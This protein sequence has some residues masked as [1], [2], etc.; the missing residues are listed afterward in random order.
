M[1]IVQIEKNLQKLVKSSNEKTF[2]YKLLLAYGLPKASI[3]RIQKGNLNLSKVK[4]EIAWKKKLFFKEIKDEDLHFAIDSFSSNSKATKH[5]PRFIVVTDYKTLLAIDTK[6]DDKLDIPIKDIA[7]HFDFFLPWAGMEKAQYQ[8]ENPADVKAA[9]R[10]AKLFDEIKKDNPGT[11]PKFLHNLNVFLSR[12]LFCFFAEDT[13]IFKDNQFTNGIISHTQPDGSDLNKYFDKLFD[14]LNT[15]SSKNVPAYLE[16][17]PYVNG[18]LFK[19]KLKSP[20]FTRRSR[21]VIIESGGLG[22]S[23]INPDIFGSMMQAV[24]THEHRGGLGMHYT[25]VPNIMKVIEPLF[26]SDLHEEFEK[27]KH[28]PL[29]LQVT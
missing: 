5:D 25:S 15:K 2:I 21:Q 19:H 13:G 29:R 23:A 28:H 10:M 24:V 22:W 6:T 9:V 17:Y 8:E 14:V 27:S 4:G 7:K 20:I 18:G 26:L 1:N 12:L 16:A 3:T 11:S